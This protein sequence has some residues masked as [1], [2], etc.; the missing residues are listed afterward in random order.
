GEDVSETI[1]AIL[2]ATPNWGALPTDVPASI[3]RLLRR[4]LE[5]DRSVRLRDIGDARFE[6]L[7]TTRLQPDLAPAQPPRRLTR[8]RLIWST[9]LALV[10]TA[11]AALAFRGLTDR[12]QPGN[13]MRL[14]VAAPPS[15][16]SALAISPDGRHIVFPAASNGTSELWVRSLNETN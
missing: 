2:R 16:D 6:I 11:A 1:A 4:C 10:V 8:E 5:K 12:S 14:D 13:E 3:P 7:D 15:N 9:A